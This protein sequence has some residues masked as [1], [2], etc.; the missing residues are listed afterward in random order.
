MADWSFHCF[1]RKLFNFLKLKSEL[2]AIIPC[3]M[4]PV[5]LKT[6]YRARI[7]I[8]D[9]MYICHRSI[10]DHL[11]RLSTHDHSDITCHIL[12]YIKG[13]RLIIYQILLCCIR[14][15]AKHKCWRTVFQVVVDCIP[16]QKANASVKGTTTNI[17]W[18]FL[19]AYVYLRCHFISQFRH[20]RL[21]SFLPGSQ[22]PM[23]RGITN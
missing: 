11:H 6:Y 19:L 21:N 22:Y 14:V 20:C 2:H 8:I 15:K 12:P 16:T 3:A 7:P 17:L 5:H 23:E 13:Q 4:K 18:V 10:I 1:V 9:H